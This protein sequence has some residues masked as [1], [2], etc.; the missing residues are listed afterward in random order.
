M[1]GFHMAKRFLQLIPSRDTLIFIKKNHHAFVLVTFIAER[2]RRENGYSDG[3]IIGDALIGSNDLMPEM[4]RQ[5]FRT[6]LKKLV[7]FGYVEIV[8][9]GKKLLTHRNLT[10]NLTIKCMLVNLVGS[11]IYDINSVEANQQANQQL[12]NSQ[13]TANHK[14]ERNKE[15]K[16]EEVYEK[17]KIQKESIAKELTPEEKVAT[18]LLGFFYLSIKRNS[19][20]MELAPPHANPKNVKI[21]L[22]LLKKHGEENVKLVITYAHESDFWI[23]FIL[24]VESLEK[25]FNTPKATKAARCRYRFQS[26]L[27][28]ENRARMEIRKLEARGIVATCR[29]LSASRTKH[30][31]SH[32]PV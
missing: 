21:M 27:R 2:A 11:D 18:A 5:N 14:Q 20:D 30:N 16:K 1:R 12:T 15:R 10:I 32:H 3:L 13:P 22:R 26:Q 25:K 19:P 24:K 6:A 28:T 31:M 9:N 7:K 17:E 4:S 23:P 8:H 29:N